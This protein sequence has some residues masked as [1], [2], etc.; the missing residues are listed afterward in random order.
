MILY[1]IS[2][3]IA[4]GQRGVPPLVDWWMLK[5]LHSEANFMSHQLHA[6][7][8]LTYTQ[9]GRFPQVLR[10]LLL[11]D[12]SC[13][14]SE[15]AKSKQSRIHLLKQSISTVWKKKKKR[16]RRNSIKKILE[17]ILAEATVTVK[18][19]AVGIRHT[20]CLLCNL[21]NSLT[22]FYHFSYSNGQKKCNEKH[23]TTRTS[24]TT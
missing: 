24:R 18:A 1:L 13:F 9:M 11:C 4:T 2:P 21:I 23:K 12:V 6:N 20:L 15:E 8:D 19:S 7:L 16:R 3:N 22:Q 10:R 17:K 5:F 14:F